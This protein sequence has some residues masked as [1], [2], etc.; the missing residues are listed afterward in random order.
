ML[1]IIWL[2]IF[3]LSVVP[4]IVQRNIYGPTGYCKPSWTCLGL[5]FC[6]T[7]LHRVLDQA[8]HDG[9]NRTR[10]H[11]VVVGG[12]TECHCI[13]VPWSRCQAMEGETEKHIYVF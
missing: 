11:L 9:A 12:R 4:N 13:Y 8:E 2:V 6:L 1:A 5:T 3:V 10:V 7:L